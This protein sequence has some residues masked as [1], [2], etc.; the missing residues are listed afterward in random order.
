MGVIAMKNKN[1]ASVNIGIDADSRKS[2]AEYLSTVLADS[3]LLLLKTHYYHWNVT[4]EHFQSLHTMF[5]TQYNELFAAVDEVAERIRSLGFI[6]PGTYH[7]YA[8]LS[9]IAEDKS[10]PDS[11]KDMVNNL[12]E[13][14]EAIARKL[15]EGIAIAGEAGDDTT[16]DLLTGRLAAH[17]KTA[18]MLRS[19][20]G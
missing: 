6:A 1:G 9:T 15:H 16:T 19:L 5:E 13:A 3:Y 10:L 7:E 18:W 17:E 20:L 11:W 8:E 4:G 2:M 14:H 12:V